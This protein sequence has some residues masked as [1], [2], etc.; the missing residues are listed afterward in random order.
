MTS[1]NQDEVDPRVEFLKE[2]MTSRSLSVS[3]PMEAAAAFDQIRQAFTP[4]FPTISPVVAGYLISAGLVR[5]RQRLRI[6]ESS[7]QTMKELLQDLDEFETASIQLPLLSRTG[8]INRVNVLLEVSLTDSAWRIV[9]SLETGWNKLFPTMSAG[10]F[11]GYFMLFGLWWFKDCLG[12]SNNYPG[13]LR[14]VLEQMMASGE[15]D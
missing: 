12:S 14:Q 3:L 9:D 11:R 4:H 10:Q 8:E 1:G 2:G 7:I 6:L 15:F 5:F 13:A